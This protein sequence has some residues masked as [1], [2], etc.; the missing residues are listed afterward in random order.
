MGAFLALLGPLL[1]KFLPSVQGVIDYK[2]KQVEATQ[3]LELAK[4][5]AEKQAIISGNQATTDQTRDKLAATTCVFKQHTFYFLILPIVLSVFMPD[6]AAVMWHNFDI[7]P[8]WFRTLFGAVYCTIWGIPLATGYIGGI[9][10]GIGDA[11]DKRRTF[12]LGKIELN[13]KA[14]FDVLK[15]KVFLKGMTAQ[16]VA[17]VDEALNQASTSGAQDNSTIQG[18]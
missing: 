3:Q 2:T 9:F 1:S 16:Q 4:I 7:I 17:A 11:I 15:A 8:V 14:A 13:R 12:A 6:K 18:Q 10:S 5:E